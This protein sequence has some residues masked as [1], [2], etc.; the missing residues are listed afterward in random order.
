MANTIDLIDLVSV[1]KYGLNFEVAGAWKGK[2]FRINI[3]VECDGRDIE[4]ES[5][6]DGGY[7]PMHD[8]DGTGPEFFNEV[9]CEDE[10]FK[11]LSNAG[12]KAWARP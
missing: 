8:W 6:Y 9:V 3:S 7:N 2:D 11:R 5:V 10:R 12:Y 1:D 4:S